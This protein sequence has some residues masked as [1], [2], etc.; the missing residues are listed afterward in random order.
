MIVCLDGK[1]KLHL[2]TC[3]HNAK[4]AVCPQGKVT[5]GTRDAVI[6]TV[7]SH[8]YATFTSDRLSTLQSHTELAYQR[9]RLEWQGY[10]RTEAPDQ[11]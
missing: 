2:P 3:P 11:A 4:Y 8:K 6:D 1:G 7:Q 9:T 10:L 5:I